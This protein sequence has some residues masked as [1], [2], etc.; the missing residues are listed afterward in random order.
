ME[1]N[2]A[3]KKQLDSSELRRKGLTTFNGGRRHF[4]R[5]RGKKRRADT[6][7][8]Q[9]EGHPLMGSWRSPELIRN[10]NPF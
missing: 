6:H 9:R 3:E 5:P 1:F 8:T 10:L 2:F 4:D 7:L